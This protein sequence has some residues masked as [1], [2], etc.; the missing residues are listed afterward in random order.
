MHRKKKK[1]KKK[2]TKLGKKRLVSRMAHFDRTRIWEPRRQKHN[3]FQ[4]TW[5]NYCCLFFE[6]KR[7]RKKSK[8]TCNIPLYL[9]E[10]CFNANFY[11]LG[12]QSFLYSATLLGPRKQYLIYLWVKQNNIW[13]LIYLYRYTWAYNSIDIHMHGC[14]FRRFGSMKPKNVQALV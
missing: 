6:R 1:R 4:L 3:I 9:D 13:I 8:F 10:D 12:H 2:K 14:S 7:P 5:K 11:L